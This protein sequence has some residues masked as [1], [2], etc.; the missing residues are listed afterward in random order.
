MRERLVERLMLTSA[1]AGLALGGFT[2]AGLAQEAADGAAAQ[3]PDCE[4]GL[5]CPSA[6]AI[7][8]D[9]VVLS[10]TKTKSA[11]V[12]TLASMSV[13]RLDDDS[14]PQATTIP[15]TLR[16][17]P[18]VAVSSSA[19]DPG[20][21]V[22]IRG[23]EGFGRVA[24]IVDGAR[25][26][27]QQSDHGP[28]GTFY[29]D[30]SLLQDVTVIRGPVAN[31]YGSGAIGGVVNFRTKNPSDFLKA[32]ETWA[33]QSRTVL[34]T[35]GSDA[36]SGVT[37][38]YRVSDAFSVLASGNFYRGSDY[39][40]G[41]GERVHNTG[42]RIGAGLLK[43]EITP[44]DHHTITLGYL[45][46]RFDFDTG[47]VTA[48]QY[49]V[50]VL[51]QT[52]S[53]RWEYDNP[54]DDLLNFQISAYY[55][56]TDKDEDYLTGTSAGSS[57]SFD[58][59]TTGFDVANTSRFTTGDFG[60]AVTVGG[61]FFRDDVKTKDAAGTGDLYTPSGERSAWGLFV[62]DQITYSSWLE[63]IGALR[64]DGYSLEGGDAESDGSRISPKITVGVKPFEETFA[65]GLQ[66]Y[67]SYAE[68]YRA[69]AVTETLING[70]HPGFAAFTFV[71]NPNLKPETAHNFEVGVNY[72][73]D[74]LF[75][76]DDKLRLKAAWFHNEVDDYIDGVFN[77]TGN[78]ATSTYTY[79]NVA[80]ATLTGVEFEAVYDAG[81][82]YA[83]LG[84][85]VVRGDNDDTGEPL[86]TVPAA[87]ITTT[88][89]MRFLDE[90]L[91]LG[92][93]WQAVFAQDR[94][95]AGTPASQSYNLVNLFA[96]YQATDNLALGLDVKNL[97]DET[98]TEYLSEQPSEGLSVM[99]SL[100]ARLGG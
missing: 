35:N 34:E 66:V 90:R 39:E 8:L 84:A 71:P 78:W 4:P 59:A 55:T 28:S 2:A 70:V 13:V 54:E 91:S 86:T 95:P 83:G 53:A 22:N 41:D 63:V 51:Q 10:A 25:Q 30:P 24:V 52:A 100:T 38:A 19:S 12:D 3:T 14:R 88:A 67:G 81:R 99:V 74:G 21:G 20:M 73:R 43:A 23:L 48:T 62:Q 45:V 40:D 46:N 44:A 80:N 68:G 85:S 89:G 98:Y 42:E 87:S 94:V 11:P 69:P 37:A 75:T 7:V 64:Y 93:Q 31:V 36:Q 16:T 79:E 17:V 77:F 49:G 29:L 97:L 33:V 27:F 26:N 15:E 9:T 60:H 1:L 32:D 47:A 58:I 50:D 61:D 56:G 96:R 6:D 5:A 65:E 76:P 82:Y 92:A 57:R 72:T 18:G